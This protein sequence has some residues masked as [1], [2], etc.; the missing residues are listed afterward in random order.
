MVLAGANAHDSKIFEELVDGVEPVKGARGHPRQRSDKLHADKGYDYPRCRRFLRSRGIRAKMAGRSVESSERLDRHFWTVERTFAWLPC[1]RRVMLHYDRR[2]DMHE[3]FLELERF[4]K[5]VVHVP[6]CT[7]ERLPRVY[8]VRCNGAGQRREHAPP[9][10]V[11]APPQRIVWAGA[12]SGAGSNMTPD[13]Q[14]LT[15]VSA[16][17]YSAYR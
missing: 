9:E 14:N 3:A 13:V 17:V 11:G 15:K 4:A 16:R 12:L 2:A 10:G 6:P 1:H 7:R 8:G 5:Q